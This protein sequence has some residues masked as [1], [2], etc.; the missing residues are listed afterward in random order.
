MD[1]CVYEREGK[2]EMDDVG[3][4]H[5]H[6]P[7]SKKKE[8]EK[9]ILIFLGIRILLLLLTRCAAAHFLVGGLL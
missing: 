1:P 4:D 9:N 7:N 5:S 6:K 2:V 3:I 8:E